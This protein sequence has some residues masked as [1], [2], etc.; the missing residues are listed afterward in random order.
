MYQYKLDLEGALEQNLDSIKLARALNSEHVPYLYQV[1][2]DGPCLN[3]Q[4]VTIA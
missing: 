3:Q 2:K 1:Q 4:K